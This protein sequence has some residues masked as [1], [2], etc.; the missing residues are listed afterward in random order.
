MFMGLSKALEILKSFNL[1]V[2]AGFSAKDLLFRRSLLE[3]VTFFFKKVAFGSFFLPF[4]TKSFPD[5]GRLL[6]SK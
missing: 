6:L 3:V 5:R 1:L 4:V 2:I